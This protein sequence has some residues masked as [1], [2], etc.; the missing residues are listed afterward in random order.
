MSLDALDVLVVDDDQAIRELV[1]E[2][3]E[4]QG[5]QI[6]T[7]E[8]GEL[9]LSAFA[10]KRADIVLL[11]LS[12]PGMN[13][14]EVCKALR[15]SESGRYV[16]IVILTASD[17]KES[18]DRAFEVGASD[19]IR[20][21]LHP[22]LLVHR[23]QFLMRTQ[24]ISDQFRARESNMLQAQRSARMGTWEFSLDQR[25]FI[26]STVLTD[27]LGIDSNALPEDIFFNSIHPDDRDRVEIAFDRALENQSETQIEFRWQTADEKTWILIMQTWASQ[28]NPSLAGQDKPDLAG[29]IKDVTERREAEARIRKLAYYDNTTGLPNRSLLIEHLDQAAALAKRQKHAMAVLLIDLDHF[30][31]I[32]ERWGHQT[33]DEV[34]E[35]IAIRLKSCLRSTDVVASAAVSSPSAN[36]SRKVLARIG[37][38]EFVILLSRLRQSEDAALVAK[39]VNEAISAPFIVKEAEVH[40]GCSI[41]ISV[42]PDDAS[43]SQVLLKQADSAMY[44][45][46]KSGR[47]G[48][49]FYTA[50]IHEQALSRINLEARL[51]R[52]IQE[53][54]FVLHYQPKL[55]CQ[56][57]QVIGVEALVRWIDPDHGVVS[58]GEF[59]P[60]AE[61]T[62]LIVPIGQWVADTACKEMKSLH[63]ALGTPMPVSV[64]LSARQ[65]KQKDLVERMVHSAKVSGLAPGCLELE[66]TESLLVEEADRQVTLLHQLKANGIQLSIDDFGTG[67]SSLAYLKRFPIDRLKIDQSF[68]RD[69]ESEE[70]DAAIV[71]AAIT[72]AHNLGMQVVAEGVET[73]AQH[74]RLVQMKCDSV[75]GYLHS[76]PLAYADLLAWLKQRA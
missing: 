23:L 24:R 64:N 27:V 20:K 12:I 36:A 68:I 28:D 17:D 10:S 71:S 2:H 54:Q 5:C 33:G 50:S 47:N 74:D 34:L 61:E 56:T 53:Q 66:L 26:C 8:D 69:L 60:L 41:G 1:R 58:P 52:A 48:F 37:G 40:L 35:E 32:N 29:M 57:G 7:A 21:P 30:K 11:D 55:H 14:F 31:M 9:G 63:D 72:L 25:A 59:I 42:C 73:Q 46:K 6:R 75:Q 65:L 67:Y 16:P 13:G 3:L 62:G 39:R 49:Q 43:D 76:R 18:I 4:F 44:E 45:A 51:R 38:D 15:Q 22:D 19:F 70:K